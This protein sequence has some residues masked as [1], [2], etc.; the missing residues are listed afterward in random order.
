MFSTILKALWKA[1]LCFFN[2]ILKSTQCSFKAVGIAQLTTNPHD[3][4]PNPT[5]RGVDFTS[6][7]ERLETARSLIVSPY[8][9]LSHKI[10][11]VQNSIWRLRQYAL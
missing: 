1:L 3:D 10:A 11:D 7:D 5:S 2:Y 9:A 8:P 6:L 4:R